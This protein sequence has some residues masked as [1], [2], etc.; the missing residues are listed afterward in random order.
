MHKYAYTLLHFFFKTADISIAN[1][2]RTKHGHTIPRLLRQAVKRMQ[3]LT[4][5]YTYTGHQSL[6]M[7]IVR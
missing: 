1:L 2:V 6:K 5:F 3:E 7:N 4:M